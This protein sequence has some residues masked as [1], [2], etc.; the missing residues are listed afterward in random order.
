MGMHG[1]PQKGIRVGFQL[2]FQHFQNT[3]SVTNTL[4][5]E[6]KDISSL[7]LNEI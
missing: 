1:C 5:T 2:I 4:S 3:Y 7:I 6:L